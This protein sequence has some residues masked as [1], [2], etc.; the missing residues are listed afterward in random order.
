MKR[1]F[2][3][4]QTN[5]KKSLEERNIQPKEVV[6]T[7]KCFEDTNHLLK[8]KK[9]IF[10]EKKEECLKCE[11]FGDFWIIFQ[12]FFDFYSY[13]LLDVVVKSSLG[14]DTDRKNLKEYQQE[15]EG[16]SKEVMRK[17]TPYMDSITATKTDITVKINQDYGKLSKG[18]LHEF[19]KKLSSAIDV[20]PDLLCLNCL[21][22]GCIV[23]TY[24][25]PLIVEFAAFP[26]TSQQ[27]K[28]LSLL[29]VIRL[30]CGRY[31]FPKEV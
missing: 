14:T 21:E 17:Y 24:H 20:E 1:L 27:E 11:K 9:L 16:Y 25:T 13:V 29:G 22:D 12:D 8:E 31:Q 19:Q 3:E 10:L 15:F 26:L 5:I 18:H 4:L 30:Q 6:T 23:L 2:N 7:L 28:A